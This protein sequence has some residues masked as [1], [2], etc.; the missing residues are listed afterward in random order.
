MHVGCFNFGFSFVS[1]SKNGSAWEK[2]YAQLKYY[3]S[4]EQY[5]PHDYNGT[6]FATIDLTLNHDE[7]KMFSKDLMWSVLQTFTL[8]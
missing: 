1:T 4:D 5:T 6:I 8:L 7:N 2:V 3:A